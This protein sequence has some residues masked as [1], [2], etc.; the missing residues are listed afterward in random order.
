MTVDPDDRAAGEALHALDWNVWPRRND[1]DPLGGR[2]DKRP[3]ASRR[4]LRKPIPCKANHMKFT[5]SRP[6]CH[7]SISVNLFIVAITF[8]PPNSQTLKLSNFLIHPHQ[9]SP[10]ILLRVEVLD[11]LPAILDQRLSLL[12]MRQEIHHNLR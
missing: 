3:D 10:H 1:D 9:L 6:F 12:G 7:A 11:N 8:N 4:I 5:S 2:L